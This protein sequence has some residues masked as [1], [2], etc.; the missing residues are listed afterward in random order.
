MERTKEDNPLPA[1]EQVLFKEVRRSMNG[2]GRMWD[3]FGQFKEACRS[4]NGESRMW[5]LF[6]RQDKPC[7][8][9]SHHIHHER[10]TL[11][12]SLKRN[13]GMVERLGNKW[14]TIDGSRT[15]IDCN[16]IGRKDYEEV[17]EEDRRQSLQVVTIAVVVA[18]P[19]HEPRLVKHRLSKGT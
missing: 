4:M 14:T 11:E 5:D 17:T 9:G 8:I 6:H 2:E 16:T 15:V 18:Q 10:D 1:V 13:T 12:F 7:S 19:P 3:R